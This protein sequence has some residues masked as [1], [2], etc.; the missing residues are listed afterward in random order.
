M[1]FDTEI[2]LKLPSAG[3]L[4]HGF[5]VFVDPMGAPG[6]TN[7]RNYGSD[8]YV[9]LSPSADAALKMEQIRHTYLHYLLDP[10]ALKYPMTLKRMEPLLTAVKTAPMDQSFKN[11]DSLLVTE[12]LI[13]AIEARTLGTSKTPETERA[14]AVDASMRQGFVLT[15]YFYDALVK[16]EKDPAGLRTAY[17]DMLAGIDVSKQEKAAQQV[18]FAAKSDPELLHL[19]PANQG[20]LLITAQQR[21]S[22]GDAAAAQKLAEEALQDKNEDQGRALFILAQ[23]S[24]MNRD[25]SGARD[26]FQKAIEAAKEP[27]VVA[28]S[29]IYLGRIFDLQADREAALN[30]YKAALDAGVPEAKTAAE[31]GIEQPYE[32]PHAQAQ[33]PQPQPQQ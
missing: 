29:H 16:F 19:S 2:Y 26:Y 28:W 18:Q 17:G 33:P 4:G 31:R 3:Y 12:C 7:A 1:V 10:M 20:K 25:M 9:V 27:K 14:K 23:V 21:L 32:P 13:R 15:Q 30:Q 8:Y 6:Q 22:A 24:A 11:D 5:T